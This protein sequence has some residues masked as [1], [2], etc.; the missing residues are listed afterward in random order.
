[1]RFIFSHSA[2]REGWDNPNV[3]QICTLK[4]SSSEVRKRQEVG[5][6]MR[7]CV[8]EDGERM[9]ENALGNDVH[10]INVLTVIASESYDKFA[11]SLQAEIAE[12]VG[13]RF[14]DDKK[15]TPENARSNNVER[16]AD[17]DNDVPK[18]K[19]LSYMIDF[20]TNELVREA[21]DALDNR[22]RVP[23]IFFE[24]ETGTMR[25]IKSKDDLLSGA[26]FEKEEIDTDGKTKIFAKTSVKYD[27]VGK[28]VSETGL[29]RKAV[30]QILTG[31]QP[32]VFNQ[33]KDNPEEF[34]IQAAKLINIQ[35]TK[36]SHKTPFLSRD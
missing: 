32:L 9:D 34:I 35:L 4:Q 1:V 26:S 15:M 25:E 24:I 21:I 23:K 16:R 22:L 3:F 5:R 17:K 7:L 31:I 12:A 29:T 11:K 10:N 13:D 27:L 6:G 33:F 19:S 14:Y 2:L 8:N 20:D 28:L 18:F 30:I 36:M